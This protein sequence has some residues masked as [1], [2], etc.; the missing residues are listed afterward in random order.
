M[1][2]S[3]ISLGC[4][5]LKIFIINYKSFLISIKKRKNQKSK[6]NGR[7]V[8]QY[9]NSVFVGMNRL[10]YL[11]V[12]FHVLYL[13]WIM[14]VHF[15]LNRKEKIYLLEREGKDSS[16]SIVFRWMLEIR[17]IISEGFDGNFSFLKPRPWESIS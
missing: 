2:S 16:I 17:R 14:F 6:Q 15:K 5:M 8:K 10:H 4:P 3:S 7:K 9:C 11:S 1:L 13:P 12:V